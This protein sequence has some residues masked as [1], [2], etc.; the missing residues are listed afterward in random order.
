MKYKKFLDYQSGSISCNKRWVYVWQMYCRKINILLLPNRFFPSF[1]K[2]C[3]VCVCKW[4]QMIDSV[5]SHSI[6]THRENILIW[7]NPRKE[8]NLVLNKFLFSPLCLFLHSNINFYARL[9]S[10][11]FLIFVKTL[12]GSRKSKNN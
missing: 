12:N 6:H 4:A 3:N 1:T 11:N 8:L 2:K 7:E 5:L 10:R 9:V